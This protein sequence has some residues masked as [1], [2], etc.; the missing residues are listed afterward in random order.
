MDET[1]QALSLKGKDA[2]QPRASHGS[3]QEVLAL[4]R[5]YARDSVNSQDISVIIQAMRKLRE[6]IVATGRTDLFA[7]NVYVF[8]IRA[9]ILVQ[10]FESYH[11]AL[12]HLL[13]TIHSKTPLSES[14]LHE[15]FGYRIL[16]LACR[17]QDMNAAYR[18]R[19]IYGLHNSNVDILLN[20]IVHGRWFSYWKMESLMD[21]YQKCLM[22]PAHDHIRRH[23][24][25]CLGKSYLKIER[26]YFEKAAHEGWVKLK[27]EHRISW[28]AEEESIIIRQMKRR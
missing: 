15:M 4:D 17:Q 22:L 11:P 18:V 13:N 9:T 23:A 10:H 20:A 6:A 21:R 12:L 16:D 24:I 1:F 14:A 2:N 26:N 7:Q 27:R 25:G 8:I 28:Q 3:A 19:Y 5:L